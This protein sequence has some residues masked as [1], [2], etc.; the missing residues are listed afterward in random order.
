MSSTKIR[1]FL[2]EIHHWQTGG[3]LYNQQVISYLTRFLPVEAIVISPEGD[4]PGEWEER[5]D[6]IAVIDTLLLNNSRFVQFLG[7]IKERVPL[8]LLVH[9]LNL[10]DPE[11][12]SSQVERELRLLSLFSGFIVTS[13]YSAEC[14]KERGIAPEKI[15]VALPGLDPVFRRLLPGVDRPDGVHLLTVSNILPGKGLL[16]LIDILER[17]LR[18]SW[19]WE[20][21]GDHRLNPTF[22][23]KFRRRLDASPIASR[24]RLGGVVKNKELLQVYNRSDIFLLPS[25]FES[26]SMASQEALA[27]G[28][29][30]LAYRVGGLPEILTRREAGT[31]LPPQRPD[32][33]VREL[34][35]WL[36]DA[37][38]RREMSKAA[39]ELGTSFP[40]WEQTGEKVYRFLRQFTGANNLQKDHGSKI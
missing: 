32:A 8:I 38:L 12:P 16:E 1:F 30:V 2:P 40:G 27:S 21:V 14:L 33:F 13:R 34:A 18:F 20:L 36:E 24:V 22:Y 31:L 35:R 19:Q 11:N 7:K 9:Y 26:F 39:R 5:S 15:G 25:R 28:L 17:L 37:A 23:R 10:L 4:F 29:P 6:Q 3:N